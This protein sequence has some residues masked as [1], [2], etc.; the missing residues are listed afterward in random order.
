MKTNAVTF[1]E[2]SGLFTIPERGG[3]SYLGLKV[4]WTRASKLA[5]ELGECIAP[6]YRAKRFESALALYNDYQRLVEKAR[7]RN[8]ETGW[9]SSSELTPELCGMEGKRVEVVHEWESGTRE[10]VRFWVGKSTGFI[11]CH[12]AI[13]RR[14]SI[15]GYSVCLGKI[16]S[17]RT[18]A[19]R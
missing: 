14:N 17:V 12:L 3:H 5:Q 16:K 4:C 13:A 8:A 2:K 6:D 18:I 10:T 9:R 19:V 15:G 7:Q 11:P 1:D